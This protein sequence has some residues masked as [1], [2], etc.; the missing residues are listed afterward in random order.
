MVFRGL[1]HY[2]QAHQ[3]NPTL[4]VVGYLAADAKGLGLIKRPRRK[5]PPDE[6]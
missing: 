5:L 4:E 3:R 1:Y 6:T 2:T